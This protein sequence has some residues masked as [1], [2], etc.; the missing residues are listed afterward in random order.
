VQ[1]VEEITKGAREGHEQVA[2]LML[3]KLDTLIG[4]DQEG[5]EIAREAGQI[6][7]SPLSARMKKALPEARSAVERRHA[8][9]R[10]KTQPFRAASFPTRGGEG[11]D[12]QSPRAEGASRSGGLFQLPGHRTFGAFLFSWSKKLY[13]F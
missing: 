6:V 9:K 10:Q 13:K 4:E 1:V 2:E 3:D 12:I 5:W 8:A 11:Q 7:R